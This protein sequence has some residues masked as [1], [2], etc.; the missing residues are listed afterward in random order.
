VGGFLTGVDL[1]DVFPVD[2]VLLLLNVDVDIEFS[3]L[4]VFI[5]PQIYFIKWEFIKPFIV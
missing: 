5:F 4:S 2:F 1:F 3:H